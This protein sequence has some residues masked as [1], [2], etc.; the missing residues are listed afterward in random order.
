MWSSP[1]TESQCRP[2]ATAT[3]LFWGFDPDGSVLCGRKKHKVFVAIRIQHRLVEGFINIQPDN[4]NILFFLNLLRTQ[5]I[6]STMISQRFSTELVAKFF[7]RRF[8]SCSGHID[9]LNR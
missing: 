4:V 2:L 3:L 6:C 7:S 1:K 5:H 9:A 8:L